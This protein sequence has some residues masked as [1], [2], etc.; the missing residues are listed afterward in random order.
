[1][2]TLYCDKKH[3][4]GEMAEGKLDNA[5]WQYEK[6]GVTWRYLWISG[7]PVNDMVCDSGMLWRR[8]RRK[9]W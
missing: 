7:M 6:G 4:A 2:N 8:Q 3:P 5:L 1:V 9:Y